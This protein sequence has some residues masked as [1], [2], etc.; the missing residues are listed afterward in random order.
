MGGTNLLVQNNFGASL[1]GPVWHAGKTF[2]FVNYE[3]LR[4]VQAMTMVDTVPTAAEVN[5]DFS[6]SGVNIYDPT[7]T[8]PNPAFNPALPVSKTNPQYIRAAVSVQR[9][10]ERDSAEP[11]RRRRRRSC[12]A[13]TRRGPTRWT[14][15][16]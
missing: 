6:Q 2:F 16:R 4:H 3:G 1:G 14:W 10:D 11:A 7:T 13:S 12:W 15:D 5:G 9:R 8:Q